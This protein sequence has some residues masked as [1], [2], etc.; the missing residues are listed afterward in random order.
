MRNKKSNIATLY[1]MMTGAALLLVY[2]AGVGLS[3]FSTHPLARISHSH[4]AKTHGTANFCTICSHEMGECNCDHSNSTDKGLSVEKCPTSS[5]Q[6][7]A[8]HSFSSFLV[9]SFSTFSFPLPE[10]DLFTNPL[11]FPPQFF[12]DPPLHPPRLA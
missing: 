11:T 8:G 1:Q 4:Q 9:E 2:V 7:Y 10:Y 3:I 6:H 5:G 12:S